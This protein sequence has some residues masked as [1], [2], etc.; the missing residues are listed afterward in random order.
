MKEYKEVEQSEFDDF[1]LD[2]NEPTDIND[3]LMPDEAHTG[4]INALDIFYHS[5]DQK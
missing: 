3:P 4:A 5:D 2:S 1:G